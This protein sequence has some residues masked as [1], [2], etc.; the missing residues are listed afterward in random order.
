[1]LP[2]RFGRYEVLAEIGDG[3]MGRVYS[4]WDPKV[5]RVVAVKTIKNELLTS[6][7]AAEYLKRFRREAVAAGG[8]NH[9]Q[10]VRVFDIGDDFLVMEFVEGRTLHSLI[11]AAGRI[12]PA[13]TLRLL[14]PVAE[15]VDHAH[16]AGIV[17]RD[18]KPANVMVQPDGQPKL[19]D[20]GVAHLAASV[21]TTAGQVLG[22]PSYMSPEQIAGTTV[23]GRSDVYSLAVVAYEMLT[24]QPPFQGKSI[25]QVIY[26]VMH[27]SPPPPR[28]WNAALP[29]R[30]DDVFARALAKDPAQRFASACEFVGALDLRELEYELAP[31][32][33]ASAASG[34]GLAVPSGAPVSPALAQAVPAAGSALTPV[35]DEI[36]TL[37]QMPVAPPAAA[38]AA[39][40]P[41]IRRAA[42]AL[43]ALAAVTLTA[44]GWA[45][46][47]RGPEAPA[48]A[49]PVSVPSDPAPAAAAPA[50]EPAAPAPAPRSVKITRTQPPVVAEP[51]AAPSP[52]PAAVVPGELVELTDDVTPPVRTHGGPAPYPERARRMH[53][54][55][56][57]AVSM[58]VDETGV[59]TELQVVESAGH[60]LD[61]AVVESV[62]S[63]RFEPATKA[64]VRVKVRWTARQTYKTGH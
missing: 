61:A 45:A 15:A 25:T 58:I 56:T 20:F 47:R 31:V 27:E 43:A 29:A 51:Q 34:P 52:T 3:A 62:R 30:Y 49:A 38:A 44:F 32:S 6:D 55:G 42:L 13:E 16:G 60:V 37:L 35:A 41:S 40:R 5:S 28:Q 14:G 53:Q 57:V 54:E 21:M 12:E 26:R 8:L 24:G 48:T 63:W 50:A 9:P 19:M 36:A 46:L 10:V 2:E 1:M 18:I 39:S 7:T 4:A 22:S 64:G 23:T 59:P 17:H 33:E 11:R